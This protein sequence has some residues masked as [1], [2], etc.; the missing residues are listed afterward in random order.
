MNFMEFSKVNS[1]LTRFNKFDGKIHLLSYSMKGLY[2][3]KFS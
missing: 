2:R 1:R 3:G